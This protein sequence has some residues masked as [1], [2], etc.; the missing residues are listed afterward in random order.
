ML[1]WVGDRGWVSEPL[2]FKILLYVL[3]F[4]WVSPPRQV[5]FSLRYSIADRQRRT[6]SVPMIAILDVM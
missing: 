1:I 2:K 6:F 5:T 3:G 4:I